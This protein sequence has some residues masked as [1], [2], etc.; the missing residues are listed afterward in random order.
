MD[1]RQIIEGTNKHRLPWGVG[2]LWIG[3]AALFKDRTLGRAGGGGRSR[4]A[5][6]EWEVGTT[7]GATMN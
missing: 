6:D 7:F 1:P 5:S 4:P 2:G 3:L